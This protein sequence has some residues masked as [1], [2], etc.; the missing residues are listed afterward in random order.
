MIPSTLARLKTLAAS[1]AISLGLAV[2]AVADDFKVAIVLPG[3]IT[4]KSFNQSGYEGVKSAAEALDL[5]FAYSEKTAQ[6]DQPEALSD[7]ARRGY[8][9]VIGHGGE[10]QESVARVA[11]RFPDTQFLVVNGTE[12]GGNI[13][14]LSFNMPE[15]GYVMG[16]V[17]G[18]ASE[19]G[20][21]GY[22]G[23]QKLKFYVQLGEGFEKGFLAANPDGQV[24]TAWTN[25]WDDV[26]KGKE[27]ALNLISQGADVI[28]PSMDNA[29]VGSLQGVR[30]AGK[31]GIGIYYD[32]ISDWPETVI[33]SAIF[34]TPSALKDVITIAKNE[35]LTG[36]A[37]VFGLEHPDAA[38]IGTYGDQ[39][40][41]EVQDETAVVIEQLVSGE[42]TVD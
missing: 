31:M 20:K 7:Y 22:I 11:N 26:A 39:V 35:G 27:A 4:D 33:Q 29:V 36:S 37:Y 8:D 16:Y 1:A 38:R 24:F 2:P 18:K 30:E 25:D 40:S 21:G 10:F 42:L 6:P 5:N 23:A 3:V 13:S 9:L 41:E 17:A 34:D 12:P 32:A 14:T 19:T 15:V 28:F